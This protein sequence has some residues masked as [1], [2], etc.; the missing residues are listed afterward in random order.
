MA[1]GHADVTSSNFLNKLPKEPDFAAVNKHK[2]FLCLIYNDNRFRWTAKLP[3]LKHFIEYGAGLHGKSTS[4]GGSSKKFTC[5]HVD[6]TI[7]S[8]GPE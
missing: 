8:L 1:A 3:A 7:T 2:D 5:S 6:L 4:P